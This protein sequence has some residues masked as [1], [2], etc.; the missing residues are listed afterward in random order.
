MAGG[1]ER[2]TNVA[3]SFAVM[4]YVRKRLLIVFFSGLAILIA[5]AFAF[6]YG[7]IPSQALA[8]VLIAFVACNV[9]AVFIVMRRARANVS[10]GSSPVRPLNETTRRE[11]RGRIR[12]LQFY[13]AFLALALVYGL[14]ETRDD[15]S[16]PTLVGVSISLLIQFALIQLIRKTQKLMK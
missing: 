3:D 11:L 6:A 5:V 13:V 8:M 4:H 9:S 7:R 10:S 15:W 2:M 12:R 14:W 1:R 16:T